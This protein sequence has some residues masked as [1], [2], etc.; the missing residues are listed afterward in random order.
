M[1][2]GCSSCSAIAKNPLWSRIGKKKRKSFNASTPMSDSK[3][4]HVVAFDV[5][6]PPD[7]GG[8]M[9]VYYRCRTLKNAGYHV[10]LHCFEYGRGRQHDFSQIAHEVHYY[11]RSKSILSWLSSKPFIVATRNSPALLYRLLQDDHP[12]VFEGQHCTFWLNHPQLSNRKKMVRL[13]NIEW[14]Y[15]EGLSKR[16]NSFFERLYF[17]SE[18]RKLKQHESELQHATVLATISKSDTDYYQSRF[19][20]VI[21][22]PVGFEHF[23]GKTTAQPHGPFCL[24]HGNLSV[25][26]NSEAVHWLLDAFQQTNISEKLIIA[27]KNPDQSLVTAC[28]QHPNVQ[29]IANPDDLQLQELMQNT[30]A[31]LIIGFQ[32][33]GIKLKLL[34][35]L[36]T[37]KKCIVT[38]Q[39]IAG[40]ELD[41]LCTVIS[42]PEELAQELL[43]GK[44]LSEQESANQLAEVREL[45]SEKRLLEVVEKYL[46][47][48]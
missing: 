48:L 37:G 26:E 25:A 29:L 9:D 10:I 21:Y 34:N 12:I 35:A 44:N 27:G 7:Y 16:S 41:H 22:I 39:I 6:F 47:K 32:H 30:C 4:I 3:R 11:T 45:F 20:Q 19:E 15:Y 24:F 1:P 28:S 8:V 14:Q 23:P 17:K 18:A 33:S 31:H 2:N 36:M 13:H 40:S 38:P 43:S 5:P 42:T 46:F